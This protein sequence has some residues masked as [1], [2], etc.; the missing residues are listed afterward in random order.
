MGLDFELLHGRMLVCW[1]RHVGLSSEHQRQSSLPV[2]FIS[3]ILL[4]YI[5]YIPTKPS[6]IFKLASG[7][8][9]HAHKHHWESEFHVPYRKPFMGQTE[10]T[11]LPKQT[12]NLGRM[13]YLKFMACV[14]SLTLFVLF[15]FFFFKI[16][17]FVCFCCLDKSMFFFRTQEKFMAACRCC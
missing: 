3:S 13:A 8:V 16:M 1:V 11:K 6:T 5:P 12:G 7:R 10:V 9:L 14:G 2:D 17:S 4:N 15:F